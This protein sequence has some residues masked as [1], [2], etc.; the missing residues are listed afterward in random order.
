MQGSGFST[1]KSFLII[2]PICR[3]EGM[4][5]SRHDVLLGL[6][7][8]IGLIMLVPLLQLVGFDGAEKSDGISSLVR[9][10]FEMTGLPLTL[11]AILCVY[12]IILSLHA[13]AGRY[14]KC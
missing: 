7:E 11:P 14:Q 3:H 1:A 6:A 13:V 8:G 9:A 4:D 5:F 10:F 12:V 2:P